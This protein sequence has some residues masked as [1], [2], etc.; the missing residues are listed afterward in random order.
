[1]RGKKSIVVLL[2]A[3]VLVGAWGVASGGLGASSEAA[4]APVV[5][6]AANPL[7]DTGNF[8]A[9]EAAAFKD[10]ALYSLGPAFLDRASGSTTGV[11]LPLMIINRWLLDPYP[12]QIVRTNFVTFIYGN[13]GCAKADEGGCGFPLEVQVWPSCGRNPSVYPVDDPVAGQF[14]DREAVVVRS[15]PAFF[16]ED[17][18]R[19]E[20]QTGSATVA[21]FGQNREQLLAAALYLV[22]VN[23][24][25]TLEMESLPVTGDP[26]PLPRPAPGVIDG[27]IESCN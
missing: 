12:E 25:A 6:R 15:V 8:T 5:T 13:T 21:I 17:G 26:R 3:L 9:A 14:V 2:S 10:F 22:P 1:M 23:H 27:S 4:A 19:L 16:Y 7:P 20:I 11:V 18:S 24:K